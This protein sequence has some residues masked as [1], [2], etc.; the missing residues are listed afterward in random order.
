MA[1]VLVISLILVV[2]ITQKMY[3]HYRY[4]S[5]DRPS[6]HSGV[7]VNYEVVSCENTKLLSKKEKLKSLDSKNKYL[8]NEWFICDDPSCSEICKA[9][10]NDDHINSY[11]TIR[12]VAPSCLCGL[13]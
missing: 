1:M 9:T 3:D 8:D 13:K 11:E 10:W 5:N 4:K 12:G 2:F 6:A 7:Y